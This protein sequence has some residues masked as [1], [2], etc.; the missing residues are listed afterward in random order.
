M[1]PWERVV[2]SMC[3]VFVFGWLVYECKGCMKLD[4]C[5]DRGGRWDEAKDACSFEPE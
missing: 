5:L 1:K 2:F 3:M 4:G